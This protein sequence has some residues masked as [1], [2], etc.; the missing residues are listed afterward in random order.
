MAVLHLLLLGL[1]T[2]KGPERGEVLRGTNLFKLNDATCHKQKPPRCVI[3]IDTGT[4]GY[5]LCVSLRTRSLPASTREI[6]SKLKTFV[7]TLSR[8]P[9]ENRANRK[10]LWVGVDLF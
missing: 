8:E 7:D 9:H 3:V 2:R 1:V 5:R 6:A 10:D 4:P